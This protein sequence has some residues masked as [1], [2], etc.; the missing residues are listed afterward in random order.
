MPTRKSSVIH[1]QDGPALN[2]LF[3]LETRS[4]SVQLVQRCLGLPEL[5]EL[6]KLVRAARQP[7]EP[8][9]SALLRELGVSWSISPLDLERIPNT[10]GVLVIANHPFGMIEGVVMSGL[11][12]QLRSDTRVMANSLLA[13]FPEV[14]ENLIL[15]DPFGGGQPVASNRKGLREALAWL[16]QGGML[17]VFPAGEVSSLHF[18][19]GHVTD[20]DWNQSI[21]RLAILANVPVLPVFFEGRNG[22]PFQLAGLVH[23]RLRTALLVREFLNKRRKT[24]EIRAGNLIPPRKLHEFATDRERIEYLRRKTYVLANRKEPKKATP[25][26]LPLPSRTQHAANQRQARIVS[27]TDPILME[28]EIGALGP[29]ALLDLQGDNAVYVSNANRIPNVVREI[30]RLRE[31]TFR[32]TGEGTGRSI[33]LDNFDSYYLHLFVWNRKYRE[34]VG[35]YRLGQSDLIL[36]NFGR[37]GFYTST[38]FAYKRAFLDRLTPALET[39]RSFVRV[40]HQKSYAALLLLWRGIGAYV[41]ANPRYSV[42]FGP[43]S[44]SNEYHPGSKQ[45]IV[46][47]LKEYCGADDLARLVRARSPFRARPVSGWDTGSGTGVVW[48][49]EELSALIADLETDQKG[50]PVLLRQYLKLGGKL[51]SFNVDS[52]FSN[53]LDGLIVVDLLKTDRRLLERYLGKAGAES[54]LNWHNIRASEHISSR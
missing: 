21:A 39:G 50:V 15:V 11:L 49:I 12:Q 19:Q 40:E 20:P 23:P 36:R 34:I 44:I 27:P 6:Y 13:R 18:P 54:F 26:L 37:R 47:F 41:A 9:F 31:L 32:A 14:A 33:D 5:D 4:R 35:A 25:F 16:K 3:D 8:Y 17:G 46:R 2:G 22:V 10:G 43:V 7:S 28:Q 53:T 38:L 52:T 48:D 30:G 29:D 1:A 45:L 51:V 42:L 24:L